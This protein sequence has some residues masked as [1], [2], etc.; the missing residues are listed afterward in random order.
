MKCSFD[1]TVRKYGFLNNLVTYIGVL[2]DMLIG[3][4]QIYFMWYNF[5]RDPASAMKCLSQHMSNINAVC[6][7]H[8][9]YTIFMKF[10]IV[11]KKL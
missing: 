1:D 10:Y 11:H 7:V 2:S 6:K 4:T 3:I 9:N 5:P 8:F